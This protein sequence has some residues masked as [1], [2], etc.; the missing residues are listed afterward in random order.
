M[1]F[2]PDAPDI[3]FNK[4]AIQEGDALTL[5]CTANGRPSTYNFNKGGFTQHWGDTD[6]DQVTGGQSGGV[7]TVTKQAASYL[8]TGTYLCT[9]DNGVSDRRGR[10][11]QSAQTSVLVRGEVSHR[12][13]P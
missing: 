11:E 2:N 12:Y 9:V 6:L 8:D 13:N 5:T 1:S 7:Y 4:V 3:T 10:V